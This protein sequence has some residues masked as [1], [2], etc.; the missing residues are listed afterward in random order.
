MVN[1][2]RYITQELKEYEEK[3]LGAE[4]KILSLETKLYNDL[5]IEL[6]EYIPAIQINATQIARLDCLLAFANVAGE[7]KYIRPVIE[8]SDVIDIRQGRH[9]VIEKQ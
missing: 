4:D 3:N 5:V 1:A 8:D 2:E 6:A 7:N 9:P